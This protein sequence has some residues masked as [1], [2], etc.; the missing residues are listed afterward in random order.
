[1]ASGLIWHDLLWY[2]TVSLWSLTMFKD[3]IVMLCLINMVMFAAIL[4]EN[5]RD[6][7]SSRMGFSWTFKVYPLLNE[8]VDPE[9][10]QFFMETSLNQPQKTARVELLIYQRVT[11]PPFERPWNFV[12]SNPVVPDPFYFDLRR[13]IA[14]FWQSTPWSPVLLGASIGPRRLRWVDR[15]R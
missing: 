8:H 12:S 13:R 11:A 15:R 1:M 9:N 14:T 7:I 5:E 2:I 3:Y 6:D 4:L 10:H